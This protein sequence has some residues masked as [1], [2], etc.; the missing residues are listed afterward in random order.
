MGGLEGLSPIV[1]RS[2]ECLPSTGGLEIRGSPASF[3]SCTKEMA[4]E[5]LNLKHNS[6]GVKEISDLVSRSLKPV[7]PIGHF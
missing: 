5:F 3:E 6:F 1:N 2:Q 4:Q 7:F